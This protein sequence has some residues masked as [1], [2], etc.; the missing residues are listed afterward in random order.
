MDTRNKFEIEPEHL[1]HYERDPL[2]CTKGFRRFGDRRIDDLTYKAL[3]HYRGLGLEEFFREEVLTIGP[4]ILQS[5]IEKA[6][7]AFLR[8]SD[9]QLGLARDQIHVIL[10][11]ERM[12]Q[13]ILAG[14]YAAIFPQCHV[15]NYYLDFG[16]FVQIGQTRLK[17]DVEC[18]GLDFHGASNRQTQH[19]FRRNLDI[20]RK[21]YDIYRMNGSDI[22]RNPLYEVEKLTTFISEKITYLPQLCYFPH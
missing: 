13:D 16:L 4:N 17:V 11:G 1:C 2:D 18:D 8:I 6:V 20:S 22:N 5:P 15:S 10:P 12:S 14:N 19:D 3:E 9:F 7:F 21:G